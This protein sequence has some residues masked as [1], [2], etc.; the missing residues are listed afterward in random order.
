[1]FADLNIEAE[2]MDAQSFCIHMNQL[3]QRVELVHHINE[4]GSGKSLGI[5]LLTNMFEIRWGSRTISPQ[6]KVF[7]D[8]S[9]A[10]H[11]YNNIDLK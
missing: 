11:F 9:A 3:C 1:M 10:I 5:Y 6:K 8:R 4:D 2:K 7:E